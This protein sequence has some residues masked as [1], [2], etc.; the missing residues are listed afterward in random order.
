MPVNGFFEQ[1]RLLRTEDV[2]L[3]GEWRFGEIFLAMQ[4]AGGEHCERN[5]LGIRALREQNLAWVVT[6]A[7][8]KMDRLPRL[9]E[10][11]TLRTWPKPPKHGFVQRQQLA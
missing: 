5:G 10:T 9:L 4:E 3:N 7:R 6:R 8:V 2:D 11:V 1:T